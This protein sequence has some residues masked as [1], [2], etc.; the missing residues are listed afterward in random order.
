VCLKCGVKGVFTKHGVFNENDAIDLH[1]G[2]C[3]IKDFL[4]FNPY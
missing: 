2:K 3:R 4:E 1:Y